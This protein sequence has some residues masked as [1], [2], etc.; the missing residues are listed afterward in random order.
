M[1]N[2]VTL[3]DLKAKIVSV[4]YIVLSD[5]RTTIAHVTLVNGFSVRGEASCVSESNYNKK[6]GEKISLEKAMNELW[7]LEAYLLAEEIYQQHLKDAVPY[8]PE[9]AHCI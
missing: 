4:E 1:R 9:K 2:K 8:L 3:E 5:N 7:K 6:D